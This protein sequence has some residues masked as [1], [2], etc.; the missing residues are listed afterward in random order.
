MSTLAWTGWYVQ[1]QNALSQFDQTGTISANGQASLDFWDKKTPGSHWRIFA[2][3]VGG[4]GGNIVFGFYDWT[5]NRVPFGMLDNGGVQFNFPQAITFGPG[6]G[7]WTPTV[8]AAAP[9]SI[10]INAIMGSEF[11]QVGPWI[12]FSLNIQVVLSGTPSNMISITPPKVC[13]G[14]GSLVSA[15]I[16]PA[17]AGFF[18]AISFVRAGGNIEF[19]LPGEATFSTGTFSLIVSGRYRCV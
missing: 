16:F 19:Y 8:S 12:D 4:G 7:G 18:S 14:S 11:I 6:Y 13:V 9:M 5:H 2:D 15:S 3:N 1:V 10:S 17:G